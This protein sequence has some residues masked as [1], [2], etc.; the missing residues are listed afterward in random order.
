MLLIQ[1]VKQL[2]EEMLY[3][4]KDDVKSRKISKTVLTVAKPMKKDFG[5][6]NL[7]NA[8]GRTNT[9]QTHKKKRKL[10]EF[11]IYILT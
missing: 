1:E 9:K 4:I 2:Y 7:L 10:N 5:A 8:W 11:S 3:L 6:N